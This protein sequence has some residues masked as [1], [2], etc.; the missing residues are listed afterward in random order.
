MTAL[1]T[2]FL[3]NG[4]D[5]ANDI[6]RILGVVLIEDGGPVDYTEL[7]ESI[8]ALMHLVATEDDETPDEVIAIRAAL[9]AHVARANS[10][11]EY[12]SAGIVQ[13][14]LS[15]NDWSMLSWTELALSKLWN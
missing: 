9:L 5:A 2:M 15:S 10:L 3:F 4:W 7:E 1:I 6:A 12:S 13:S 14:I 8:R 11:G